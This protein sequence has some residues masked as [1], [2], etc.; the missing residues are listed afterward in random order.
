M[1]IVFVYAM[2]VYSFK[3]THGFYD[4]FD[5]NDCGEVAALNYNVLNCW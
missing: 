1:Q 3:P 4:L 5:F 2:H